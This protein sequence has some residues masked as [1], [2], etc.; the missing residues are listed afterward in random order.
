MQVEGRLRGMEKHPVINVC[1][2]VAALVAVTLTA[3]TAHAANLLQNGGFEIPST[4]AALAANWNIFGNA[5]ASGTNNTVVTVHTGLVS[6]S[7]GITATNVLAGSGAYQDVTT[8]PGNYRLTGY[9][10]TWINAKLTGPDSYA[11]AQ[12]V[13]LDGGNNVLQTIESPHYGTDAN[14]PVNT[15]VPF[16]V[17]GVA[18]ASTATV[19]CYLMQISDSL[20]SGSIFFDDVSLYTP[21]TSNTAS[22][23]TSAGVQVSW[24]TSARSNGVSYQVQSTK[25]LVFSNAPIVSVLTNGGFETNAAPWTTFN[26]AARSTL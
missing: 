16:E 14:L 1:R 21:S 17:D 18:P 9:L 10:L 2:L 6:L 26:N 25:S 23:T 11:V 12:L 24:P 20:D 7:A 15:W 8:G 13:F 22:V 19:R 5:A 3:A 4:N